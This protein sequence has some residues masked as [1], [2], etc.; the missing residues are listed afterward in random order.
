[1]RYLFRVSII[2][3]R[4]KS[5]WVVSVIKYPEISNLSFNGIMILKALIIHLKQIK[6][7][8]ENR[9]GVILWMYAYNFDFIHL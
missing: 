9:K 6:F 7:L 5:S 1:M 4:I 8:C 2:F 3:V